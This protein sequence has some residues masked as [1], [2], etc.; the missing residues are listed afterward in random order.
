MNL[1]G[2]HIDVS[3]AEPEDIESCLDEVTEMK[4]KYPEAWSIAVL[5]EEDELRAELEAR[6]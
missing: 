2:N 6:Q 1:L 5:F 4:K 3:D